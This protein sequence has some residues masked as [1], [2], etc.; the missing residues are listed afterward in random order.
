MKLICRSR[1]GGK[2]T[3][4]IEEAKKLEGYNLIV[5]QDKNEVRRLWQEILEKK[6][7]LPQPITFDEFLRR[8]YCG[9]NVNA[10]L[11]DNADL[12]IQYLSKGVKVHAI[13][14]N[15]E[16]EEKEDGKRL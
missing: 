12:L 8:A 4:L 13:T 3:E 5:C 11:I 7:E 10:F 9:R 15:K 2:T 1:G 16:S 14:F 6:Y